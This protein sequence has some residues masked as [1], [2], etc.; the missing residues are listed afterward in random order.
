MPG[1]HILL[2]LAL[3]WAQVPLGAQPVDVVVD[4][5]D[6]LI[7]AAEVVSLRELRELRT[8]VPGVGHEVPGMDL[9]EE[10]SPVHTAL[11]DASNALRDLEDSTWAAVS[12]VERDDLR[13]MT[14]VHWVR[15]HLVARPELKGASLLLRVV[16]RVPFEVFVNGVRTGAIDELPRS[17]IGSLMPRSDSVPV[18]EVPVRFA[19]DGEVEVIALRLT[20]TPGDA[21]QQLGL[22]VTL[23]AADRAYAV[24][25]TTFHY[26]IFI[27]INAI[28]LLLS[29]F[30]WADDRRDRG[31][32]LLALLSLASVLDTV[33]EVGGEQRLL[34][35]QDGTAD[36]LD[37]MATVLVPWPLF[38]LIMV[39]RHLRG[40][41]D[42]RGSRR[43]TWM[44]MAMTVTLLAF[45][46]AVQGGLADTT[47]GL[48]FTNT[49]IPLVVGALLGG[50]VMAVGM[51]W[52]TIEVV[53]S[54]VRLLR[55]GGYERWVGAGAVAS[56]LLTLVLQMG[57]EFTGMA[58][59]GWLSTLA[60]YCA[61][62]AVPVSVAVYLGIR[63]AHHNR[64]VARQRDEL[65][66][67]VKERTAEL[68]TEKERS[69]AL[70]LNILPAEV[71]EELKAKG[72]ADARHFDR[73]T[74]LFTDF[75]GFTQLSER[76]GPA[77]LVAEL[78]A[79]FK[80]FD[81]IM[82]RH[83]VEKIKTIGDAYMA[84]G[85]LPDPA[86]GSPADV[87]HAA[88]EMQEFMV[89]HKA[90]REAQGRPWFEMRVGIHS[91]PV[92]AGIV[93]VKKFQYDIWGDT[94]NTAARME[95]SGEVGRVNIS[96]ATH[97]LLKEVPGLVF[98]PRG[99][100]QAKGK[101]ELEMYFVHRSA[102][103]ISA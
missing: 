88:L 76:V 54:G 51:V 100:V 24:Q 2:C 31:W 33:A 95:S 94:V 40:D 52:F 28:I 101:G 98:T 72:A 67:E 23:H 89:R 68:R 84:A 80:A 70:L 87:V 59:S 34:G 18:V 50:L 78:N 15:L 99:K 58:L 39:L 63:S 65:D 93:G 79:C 49:S 42:A 11:D 45:V 55:S 20:G 16:S 66:A 61:Y 26:G 97:A 48:S 25:R 44:V 14:G 102:D 9:M 19:A 35:L 86:H 64:L 73:A 47:N 17:S 3:S 85:G 32:G 81:A 29:L 46:A 74:V 56:L 82:E 12:R 22:R 5:V 41:A 6:T 1:K 7:R 10:C 37:A 62:V 69:D 57:S 75:R 38:L 13:S 103:A 77:E 4:E 71:A 91:G 53:R 60:D 83:R 92:V 27:G 8:E 36:M 43:F 96:G 21:L 90:D 30:I